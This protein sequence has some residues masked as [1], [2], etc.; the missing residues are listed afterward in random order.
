[1]PP[2]ETKKQAALKRAVA[3]LQEAGIAAPLIKA[4]KDDP[5]LLAELEKLHPGPGPIA[6]DWSCCFRDRACPPS[7]RWA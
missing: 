5:K 6:G 2:K 4:V 7:S 1:M 3:D